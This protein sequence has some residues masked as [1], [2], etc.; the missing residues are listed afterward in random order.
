MRRYEFGSA[1]VKPPKRV[2]FR[3]IA[4]G[5]QGSP[6][7]SSASYER[8]SPY[9]AQQVSRS[10]FSIESVLHALCLS[11]LRSVSYACSPLPKEALKSVFQAKRRAAL[12]NK[13]QRWFERLV[14][15]GSKHSVRVSVP[16]TKILKPPSVD[17]SRE[18]QA[19]HKS[20]RKA[21]HSHS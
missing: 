1:S 17:K 8:I 2:L 16:E 14:V 5:F 4:A 7:V 18:L 9:R 10:K 12:R 13:Y 20:F 21:P 6:S 15:T 3:R 11:E 19:F